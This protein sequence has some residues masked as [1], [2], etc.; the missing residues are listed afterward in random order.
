MAVQ[1]PL[2]VYQRCCRV[3]L[4]WHPQMAFGRG[5]SRDT[6]LEH[7]GKREVKVTKVKVTK[8]KG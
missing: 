5:Q 2:P 4:K 3:E 6:S 8:V 7:K 1:G